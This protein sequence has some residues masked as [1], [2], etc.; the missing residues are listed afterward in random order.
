MSNDTSVVS[1]PGIADFQPFSVK[2]GQQFHGY[3]YATNARR[4]EGAEI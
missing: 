2:K 1:A 4:I 3:R